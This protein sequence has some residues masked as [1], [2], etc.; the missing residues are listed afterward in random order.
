MKMTLLG[1]SLALAGFL[2]ATLPL[3]AEQPFSFASTPGKLPKDIAPRSYAIVLRPDAAALTT[4]GEVTVELDV[5]QAT[6]A[7]VFNVNELAVPAATLDGRPVA[8][9]V[10]DGA[11]QTATIALA[12]P[13]EPGRHTLK[14]SFRGKIGRNP[15]G[16]YAEKYK[17]D[18][19]EKQML[20]TQ[21]EPTDARRMF[22]CWDEPVFRATFQLSV[23]VP[24]GQVA[25]SN[26]PVARERPL[27]GG[28]REVAFAPSPAMPSYLVVLCM[29]ELESITDEV[30]G[31]KLAIWTTKGKSEQA[32]YALG[33]TKQ[34]VRFYNEYFGVKYP[35]PKLDQIA[36]PGGFSGAM[37]N[38]GGIT[39]NE[40]AL[41]FDPATSSQATKEGVFGTV[42]HEIAHQWFGNL[43][44]MAWWDNLWLNE[45]FA[46][47]MGTKC[48]DHF[49]PGWQIWLRA[50]ASKEGVMES[51]ARRSTHAI[52]QPVL[53]ESAATDA[54]DN[55]TYSKG[56][57]FIRMLETYLGESDFRAGIRAYMAQH[58]YSNTTSADLWAA[59][60]KASGKS[61]AL[62]ADGWTTQPGFP[63]V[64]V[65]TRD[66][67]GG[68]EVALTQEHYTVNDPLPAEREW[69]IPVTIA[70]VDQPERVQTVMLEK[71]SDAA[72]LKFPTGTVVKLNVGNT[73]YYRAAYPPELAQ[74]QAARLAALPAADRANL[75][76]DAWAM[77]KAGRSDTTTYLP[78]VA[79]ADGEVSLAVWQQ[80]AGSIAFMGELAHGTPAQAGL[81]RW[82]RAWLRAP[83]ARLGWDAKPGEPATDASFRASVIGRLARLGDEDVI[84]EARRRFEAFLRQPDSLAGSL[85][86]PVFAIVGRYAD[87]AMWEKLHA[88]ARGADKTED[89]NRYYAALQSVQ[90]VALARRTLELALTEERT[91]AQW[92]GIV[93]TV[94]LAHPDLAWEFA[95]AHADALL[96]KIP[97][98]GAFLTRSRYFGGIAAASSDATRADE[99][100]AFV[101]EKLGP[102][103]AA[104]TAK[105][106]EEIRF[107]AAFKARELG[108]IEA[109]IAGGK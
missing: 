8:A 97:E 54:F 12:A 109:W 60:E 38:W 37:E 88:M 55:I 57:A 39:Y 106:A 50:H 17:V 23:A 89:Q 27:A 47:W 25:V 18:G 94:A 68:V 3:G 100:E 86:D 85:R 72:R 32:R 62:L 101:R 9:P 22:P 13:V 75:L 45:G 61:I 105:V 7:I 59:L 87:V 16:L 81:A 98:G 10:I 92:F 20:G 63:V 70:P 42:A 36:V 56:Q 15:V 51:D 35:L 103:A 90:D 40:R 6:R 30:D 58:A 52:Q 73:G 14:L 91:F 1:R 79:A 4:E 33:A 46:S 93:G 19:G 26:M 28:A 53:S 48:T 24:A 31:V 76:S 82:E 29:G 64:N 11:E 41:L 96:A 74:A 44:T 21:M 77:V 102:N 69:R 43:V 67:A 65:A 49:N 71:N 104:E 83:F 5:R 78:L 108:R 95:R 34:I 107:K 80:A 66:V 99:L 2:V 84:A